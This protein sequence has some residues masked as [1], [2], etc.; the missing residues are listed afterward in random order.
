MAAWLRRTF[1][2]L[3]LAIFLCSLALPLVP[4]AHGTWDDDEDGGP[5]IAADH[6]PVTVIQNVP[7]PVAPEHCALCHWQHA[8]AGAA[9]GE[10]VSATPRFFF[11]EFLRSSS[12]P[13]P[14]QPEPAGGSSRA[15]PSPVLA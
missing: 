5:G 1:A 15:P 6:H 12:A 8:L 10:I 3:T 2:P 11:R 7:A 9:V 14:A 13:R 4:G